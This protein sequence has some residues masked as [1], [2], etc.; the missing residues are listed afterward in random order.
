MTLAL[1]PS[2]MGRGC[3]W[4]V[5]Q[6][7][8]MHFCQH[9]W[10][11]QYPARLLAV[12][13]GGP[14]FSRHLP[15]PINRKWL[16]SSVCMVGEGEGRKGKGHGGFPIADL[17]GNWSPGK[18]LLVQHRESSM[19]VRTF[20]K[21]L[22]V[23]GQERWVIAASALFLGPRD[24]VYLSSRMHVCSNSGSNSNSNKSNSSN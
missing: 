4:G 6:K 19:G 9:L 13:Q 5:E 24:C 12:P 14:C 8:L 16:G 7:L 21:A 22:E 23:T 20:V 17:V 15:F 3:G 1:S 2:V 10:F 11:L 18:L